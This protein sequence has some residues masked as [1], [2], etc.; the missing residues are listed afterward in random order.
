MKLDFFNLNKK[1]QCG[2]MQMIPFSLNSGYLQEGEKHRKWALA[3][4][5]DEVTICLSVIFFFTIHTIRWFP[6]GYY[7][8]F[9]FFASIFLV[10]IFSICV[11]HVAAR[12][13]LEKYC[14]SSISTKDLFFFFGIQIAVL[15]ISN[16]HHRGE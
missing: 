11:V 5:E 14:R 2:K 12:M 15:Q 13:K 3:D 16:W 10:C 1:M 6:T 8:F 4:D 7:D 9:S